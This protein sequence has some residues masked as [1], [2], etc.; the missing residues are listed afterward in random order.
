MMCER[1]MSSDGC[2]AAPNSDWSGTQ[3]HMHCAELRLGASTRRTRA[4]VYLA[5][6][7]R[8]DLVLGSHRSKEW[9]VLE[10]GQHVHGRVSSKKI[11]HLCRGWHPF[12]NNDQKK[13]KK[14]SENNIYIIRPSTGRCPMAGGD[15]ARYRLKVLGGDMA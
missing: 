1:S 15:A 8:V 12:L 3:I 14:K 4:R 6:C 10:V 11:R 13:K 5:R 2:H 7:G 9:I